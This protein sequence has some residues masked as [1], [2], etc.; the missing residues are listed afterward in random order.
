MNLSTLVS[1]KVNICLLIFLLSDTHYERK[2]EMDGSLWTFNTVR[3]KIYGF[4]DRLRGG[5]DS[6]GCPQFI[7]LS[8]KLSELWR[9]DVLRPEA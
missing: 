9:R 2:P 1:M 8:I 3:K 7:V 4:T 6:D 5:D